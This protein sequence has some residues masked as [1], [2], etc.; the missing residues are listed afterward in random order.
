MLN[1]LV[2]YPI[3]GWLWGNRK[4]YGVLPKTSDPD[5]IIWQEKAYTDF[6]QKTQQKGIGN[7]VC[8]QAYPIVSQIDFKGKIV[9]EIGPGIVRHIKFM[10]TNPASYILCDVNDGLLRNAQN[11]FQAADIPCS[12]VLVNSKSGSKLPLR[13]ESVDII[14]SFNAL[15]HLNPLDSYILE[16]ERL[17]KTGGLMVG[18]V[19]CEGGMAWGLGRFLTTRHYVHKNYGINYDKII[20]WEHP[21]FI[22][23]IIERLNA[24]LEAKYL[25]FHPFPWLPMDF[26]LVV[27]FIYKRRN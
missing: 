23:F 18:G 20:C 4:R 14:I 25:N 27:S 6:Y 5:W 22:D 17:L 16:M 3:F 11:Q 19:P 26:N 15:E 1:N 2:P 7:W 8:S 12:T 9:L 21:N 24:R 10:N 13:S